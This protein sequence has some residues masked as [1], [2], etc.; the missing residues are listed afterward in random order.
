MCLTNYNN[1]PACCD[2]PL[3][4]VHNLMKS[5]FDGTANTINHAF[6]E[7]VFEVLFIC[8]VYQLNAVFSL[9][10]PEEIQVKYGLID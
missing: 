2:A 4:S 1:Y 5:L 7:S 10:I 3:E 8:S 9:S 6:I